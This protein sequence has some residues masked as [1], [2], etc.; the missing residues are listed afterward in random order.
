MSIIVSTQNTKASRA[1]NWFKN[2]N[3]KL[4][5]LDM[6]IRCLKNELN[7]IHQTQL[8]YYYSLLKEGLDFRREGLSWIVKAIW[9]LNSDVNLQHFPRF[10]DEQGVE[11]ILRMAK[12]SSKHQE[13]INKFRKLIDKENK[14]LIKKLAV[15]KS[16]VFKKTNSG[17]LQKT[18]K[19]K[20]GRASCRE[21]VYDLG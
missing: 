6:K 4:R 8:E 19:G 17:K 21:R 13:I 12:M 7:K 16:H 3:K 15:N 11:F 14:F 18:N 2:N 1:R 20:I 5:R 10:I 9:H